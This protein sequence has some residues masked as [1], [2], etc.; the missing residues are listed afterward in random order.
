MSYSTIP[1]AQAANPK[2]P[3]KSKNLKNNMCA[4]RYLQLEPVDLPPTNYN[5]SPS[6]SGF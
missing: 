1:A 5:L 2:H 3:A 6:H 4:S